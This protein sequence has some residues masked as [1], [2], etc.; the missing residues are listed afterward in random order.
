[1]KNVLSIIF[2]AAKQI[3]AKKSYKLWF[4]IVFVLFA[5]AY[6]FVPVWL[7]PGNSLD[8]Q[9]SLLAPRDYILFI[10]L[11]AVSSLL[12]LMQVFLFVRS[13]KG[14]I[15]TAVQ[16]GAGAFSAF[17]GGLLATAACSSCVAAI[18]GFLGAGSIFFILEKQPYVVAGAIALVVVSLYFSARKVIGICDDCNNIKNIQK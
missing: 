14:R 4:I 10:A 13:R 11:S 17:F 16:G 5:A 6:I 18:L 8:F 9:L 3:L 12:V 7:T 15:G 2:L 1:M